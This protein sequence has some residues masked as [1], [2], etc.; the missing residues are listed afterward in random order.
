[1]SHN[2]WNKK[3]NAREDL[4][5]FVYLDTQGI[6]WE[7]ERRLWMQKQ[8]NKKDSFLITPGIMGEKGD[9]HISGLWKHR[10]S[11]RFILFKHLYQSIVS[12]SSLGFPGSGNG[13]VTGG[14]RRFGHDKPKEI[15]RYSSLYSLHRDL[16]ET[17]RF[18][19]RCYRLL[20]SRCTLWG[21]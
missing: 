13:H 5:S 21:K 3:K 12:T 9:P 15:K 7:E 17:S 18:G 11:Y 4:L 8:E 10:L 20:W 2:K 19:K 14:A 6:Q 1:M 16:R